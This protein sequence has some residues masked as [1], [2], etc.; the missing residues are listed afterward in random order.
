M[1][2]KKN[3][4]PSQIWTQ[5]PNARVSLQPVHQ[6]ATTYNVVFIIIFKLMFIDRSSVD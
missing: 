3:F 2:E 1:T 6:P 5:R 4:S